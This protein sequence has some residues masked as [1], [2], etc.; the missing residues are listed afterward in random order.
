MH[1]PVVVG[2]ALAFTAISLGVPSANAASKDALAEANYKQVALFSLANIKPKTPVDALAAIEA[3][4]DGS[5]TTFKVAALSGKPCR[6]AKRKST[7]LRA[8]DLALSTTPT[9]EWKDDFHLQQP[10]KGRFLV[11]TRGDH[12]FAPPTDASFFGTINSAVE[13]AWLL[14]TTAIRSVPPTFVGFYS[15]N[16]SDCPITREIRAVEVQ[17]NGTT[18]EIARANSDANS[19]QPQPC[20]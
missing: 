19:D 5:G 18:R 6:T 14:R 3:A 13:A 10:V 17:R 20:I 4:H 9:T 1:H 16:V 2:A 7:C 12:V 15:R 8:W 11:A